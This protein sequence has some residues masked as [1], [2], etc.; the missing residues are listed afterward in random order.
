MII[1]FIIWSVVSLVMLGIGISVL[2]SDK[3]AGFYTGVKAPE[4]RDIKKYNRAVALLWFAYAFLLEMLGLPLMF[5]EQNPAAF[6]FSIF[7]TV[8]LSIGLSVM[9][10]RILAKH[11]K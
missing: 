1:G 3:A 4:V 10:E 2:R 8:L 6:L 7:G 5:L 9:Y 11:K